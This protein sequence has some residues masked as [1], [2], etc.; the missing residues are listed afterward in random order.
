MNRSL[1]LVGIG[2]MFGSL[3]RFLTAFFLTKWFPSPFPFGTFAV[4]LAGCLLIG[5]VYGL[6]LRTDWL[7][8]DWRVFLATGF[9]G[10]F[11]TM[12]SFSLENVILLQDK[13]HT[14]FAAYFFLSLLICPAMTFLG[15]FVT[16]I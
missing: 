15:L 5:I 7:T 2:G 3:S 6:S 11:T 1:I 10:G 12:S 9:C 16:R 13:D 8:P 4:N 14:T